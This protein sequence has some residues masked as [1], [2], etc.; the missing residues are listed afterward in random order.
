MAK[1]KAVTEIGRALLSH[2]IVSNMVSFFDWG[3]LNVGGF[4]NVRLA[5]SGAYGGDQSRLRLSDDPSYTKGQVWEGFRGNWV[6]ESGLE[7][8]YQ[9]IRISG[10]YIN[11][12]YYPTTTTGTY[13]YVINYPLGRVVF[14]SAINTASVVKCEFSYK[15]VNV[16]TADVPWFREIMFNSLRV[17]DPQFH[18]YGSGQWA[19]PAQMR[20]QLPAIVVEHGPSRKH[21]PHALG[22]GTRTQ[23]DVLFHVF[24]ETSYDRDQIVDIID[25][26]YE[27][28]IDTYDYAIVLDNNKFPLDHNGN[29]VPSA[30]MY[31]VLV[32]PDGPY[33]GQKIVFKDTRVIDQNYNLPLFEGAVKVT[34]E[35]HTPN[36]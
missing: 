26:Q 28:T 3:L 25:H 2:N 9:P 20:V 13:A 14:D 8:G 32:N 23:T 15:Y 19:V 29:I 24:A 16:T 33:K 11:N 10:I 27:H 36:I 30:L 35:I 21:T 12:A 17:D 4:T 6:W 18:Q 5:S 34:V 7:Y 31:P 1:L 22:G